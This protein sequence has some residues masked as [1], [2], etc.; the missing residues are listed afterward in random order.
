MT[1]DLKEENTQ[2]QMRFKIIR[3][4][5]SLT[6]VSRGPTSWRVEG[7][8]SLLYALQ[9]VI[10]YVTACHAILSSQGEDFT[11]ILFEQRVARALNSALD[12]N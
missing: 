9:E 2:S 6:S 12:W 3:L 1:E 10:N 11:N 4:E 7:N 8:L 5:D